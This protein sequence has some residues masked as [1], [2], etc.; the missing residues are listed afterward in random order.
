[1]TITTKDVETRLR[2]ALDATIPQLL[3]EESQLIRATDRPVWMPEEPQILALARSEPVGSRSRMPG[4]RLV[5]AAA[6]GSAGRADR[7]R[8]EPDRARVDG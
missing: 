1:M 2:A 8:A 3:S 6:V 5:G 4:W 7:R